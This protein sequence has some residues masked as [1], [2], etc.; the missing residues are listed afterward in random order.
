MVLFITQLGKGLTQEINGDGSSMLW[1]P[2]VV[3]FEDK[4][5]S[6]KRVSYVS[7]VLTWSSTLFSPAPKV[8]RKWVCKHR[9]IHKP[10]PLDSLSQL[11]QHPLVSAQKLSLYHCITLYSESRLKINLPSTFSKLQCQELTILTR[12]RRLFKVLKMPFFC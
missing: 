8:Y 4:K 7:N 10:F 2:G 1:A 5:A 12:F 3:K 9:W 11:Y 6:V